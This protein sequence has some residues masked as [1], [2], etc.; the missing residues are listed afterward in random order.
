M[1]T[2]K[3]VFVDKE[4]EDSFKL[5]DRF[6][7]RF[8]LLSDLKIIITTNN[9]RTNIINSKSNHFVYHYLV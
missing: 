6:P 5:F 7:E 2:D 1:K 3:V 4:L 9:A 8:R